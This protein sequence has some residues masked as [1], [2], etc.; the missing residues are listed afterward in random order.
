LLKSFSQSLPKN[1][2]LFKL[3]SSAFKLSIPAKKPPEET[4]KA[5][6]PERDEKPFLPQRFPSIFKLKASGTEEKPA[7]QI[8]LEGQRIVRFETDVE[9]HYFDRSED[10]GDL[11]I[12]LLSYKPKTEGESAPG[13]PRQLSD[14]L[15]VSKSS[16]DKGTIRIMLNPT[17]DVNA[18]DMIEIKASL[19]GAG[20]TFEQAFWVRI[21]DKEAPKQKTAKEDQIDEGILGL[22]DAKLVFKEKKEGSLSWEEFES[23]AGIEMNW[24]TVMHPLV[25]GDELKVIYIN[26]DSAV[27]KNYK[28][29]QRTI[30]EEQ[31]QPADK[32]YISSVYFHTLILYSITKNRNYQIQQSEKES[33]L[34]EYLKDLF[35]SHYA[36]FLLSFGTD[37][38]MASL[39]I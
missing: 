25:E 14:V 17:K 37:E 5:D 35:S 3:L 2:E 9:D 1:E 20:E 29:R 18:G 7:A 19:D 21:V 24:Q 27:L 16:P 10:P 8:P 12:S 23:N 34:T 13:E 11:Q 30:T 36:E 38:L 22:P 28:G 32:K 39:D 4:K 6:K 31:I 26:M 15:N 33:D